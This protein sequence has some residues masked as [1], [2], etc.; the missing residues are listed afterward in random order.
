M[1]LQGKGEGVAPS[2]ML[3]EPP[4]EEYRFGAQ[5]F[6]SPKVS[7]VSLADGRQRLQ[8]GNWVVAVSRVHVLLLRYTSKKRPLQDKSLALFRGSAPPS[9]PQSPSD[10]TT[11]GFLGLLL[12]RAVACERLPSVPVGSS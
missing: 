4:R 9:V 6:S 8:D 7:P 11:G 12:C 3:E 5:L 1:L 2:E 10:P